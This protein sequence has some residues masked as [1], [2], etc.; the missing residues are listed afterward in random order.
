MVTKIAGTR[1]GMKTSNGRRYD[2]FELI[3]KDR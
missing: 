3:G 2:A 1:E